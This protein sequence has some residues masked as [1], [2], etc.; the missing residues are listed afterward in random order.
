MYGDMAALAEKRGLC[1]TVESVT[2]REN[3]SLDHLAALAKKYPF[4][5]FTYDTKMAHLHGENELL[6]RKKYAP[7][8]DGGRICHLHVNDSVFPTPGMDR[9]PIMHIGEGSVDFGAFFALL[10]KRGYLG[11]ATVESTSVRPDGSVD[12]DRLN[13]SLEEVRRGLNG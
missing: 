10:K 7:L 3:L 2:C 12:L 1:L 4:A 8:L 5:R 13:H 11:T 9:L 6:A